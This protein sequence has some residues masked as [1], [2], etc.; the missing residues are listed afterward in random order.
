M[1]ITSFASQNVTQKA[2]QECQ[3]FA[4]KPLNILIDL[5]SNQ[6]GHLTDALKFSALFVTS[7]ALIRVDEGGTTAMITRPVNHPFIHAKKIIV[8]VNA[9]TAS[10]AEAS[11]YILKKHPNA[12][13]IGENTMGKTDIRRI[14]QQSSQLTRFHL[15]QG[16]IVPDIFHRFATDLDDEQ[17]HL[18]AIAMSQK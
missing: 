3:P 12:I 8:L 1:K 10:A 2:L 11:A 5:R 6:G 15:P 7:N 4:T 14:D 17:V 16:R 13:I 9:Q 18:S